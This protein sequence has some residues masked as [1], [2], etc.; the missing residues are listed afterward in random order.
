VDLIGRPYAG[1]VGERIDTPSRQVHV[2]VGANNQF[3]VFL[4]PDVSDPQMDIQDNGDL[5]LRGHATIHGDVRVAQGAVDFSVLKEP[6][7][8]QPWRIYGANRD[9]K[10]QLRVEMDDGAGNEVVIGSWSQGEFNACLTITGDCKVKVHGTL[11]VD[12]LVD[13]SN[14]SI[15]ASSA[16]LSEDAK[17]MVLGSYISGVGGASTLMDEFY[18]RLA[19]ST[20]PPVAMAA[21]SAASSPSDIARTMVENDVYAA[22]A[23]RDELNRYL[24]QG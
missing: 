6:T 22:I 16:P 23:L 18:R 13:Q 21:A 1:L 9:G 7:N 3:A 17:R 4:R 12:N 2:D 20:Q 19:Q 14:Q 15:S 24:N 5:T 10:Q 11:I 8:S